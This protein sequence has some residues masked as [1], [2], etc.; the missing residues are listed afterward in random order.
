MPDHSEVSSKDRD[1]RP[2]ARS[3]QAAQGNF[4]E[5]QTQSARSDPDQDTDLRPIALLRDP[6]MSQGMGGQS[7]RARLIRQLQR[8]SGNSYTAGVVARM[9]AEPMVVQR[10]PAPPAPA[11]TKQATPAQSPS[12]APGAAPSPVPGPA[13]GG[14]GGVGPGGAGGSGGP[15]ASSGGGAGGTGP[16]AT[17]TPASGSASGSGSGGDAGAVGVDFAAFVGSAQLAKNQ[18]FE[19][20]TARKQRIGAAADAEKIAVG[21][22]L[23][24]HVRRLG[25]LYDAGI[26]RTQ[27]TTE[28]LRTQITAARDEQVAAVRAN[29]DTELDNLTA[30]VTAN[31]TAIRQLS[32]GQAK[33]ATDGGEAEA[34]RA[35]TGSQQRADQAQAFGA[36]KIAQFAGISGA[37]DITRLVQEKLPGLIQGFQQ[38]GNELA[39]MARGDAATMAGNFTREG[40]QLASGEF[41]KPLDKGRAKI[42]S[43]RDDAVADI[44]KLAQDALKEVD[45]QSEALLRDLRAGKDRDS[46]AIR[47]SLPLAV[48]DINGGCKAAQD[49]VDASTQQGGQDV[50]QFTGEVQKA[51]PDGPFVREAQAGLDQAVQQ[52]GA[53]IDGFANSAIAAFPD[54][55]SKAREQSASMVDKVG[56]SIDKVIEFFENGGKE[57]ASKLSQKAGEIANKAHAGMREITGDASDKLGQAIREAMEKWDTQRIDGLRSISSK[58]DLGLAREDMAL[59]EFKSQ[60]D[61]KAAELGAK[62]GGSGVLAAIGDALLAVVKF[63]GGAIVGFFEQ[64]WVALKAIWEL[65]KKPLFWIVVAIVAVVLIALIIIFGWEAIVAALGYVLKALVVLGIIAGIAFASYYVYL[66][67]TK[68]NLSAYERGKLFGRAIFEVVL[69]FAGTGVWARLGRFL[70]EIGQIARLIDRIGNVLR[71][72]QLFSRIR[73][74]ELLANLLEKAGDA[75]RLLQMLDKVGDAEKLLAL[76]NK[77]GDAELTFK[78][79]EKVSSADKLLTLL[80][81]VPKAEQVLTLLEKVGDADK[82]IALLDKMPDVE[83]LL[84]LLAKVPNPDTLLS[85]LQKVADGPKLLAL[86]EKVPN[87]DTLLKLLDKLANPDQLLSLLDKVK[88]PDK[89]LQ[90][91]DVVPDFGKLQRLLDKVRD[92]DKLIQLLQKAPDADKLLELLNLIEAVTGTADADKALQ[93]LNQVPDID[94]L[95]LSIDPANKA[96]LIT[97]KGLAEGRIGLDLKTSGKLPG[98]TRDPSGAAEFL[99]GKAA[100]DI[101]GFNSS[102]PPTQGGFDLV[103]DMQKITDSISQGE[104]VIVDTSKMSPADIAA[105]QAEVARRGLASQVVFHP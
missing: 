1:L 13:D 34:A 48:E 104:N 57:L 93:A 52:H 25:D 82:L 27:D 97:P 41:T 21:Q 56:G 58:V 44:N 40:E 76:L 64:A 11:D 20:A 102:R 23:D 103:R 24:E 65:I 2:T 100:W 12:G 94:L 14:G 50:D 61:A 36:Q 62:G 72:A 92:A 88:D 26:K 54:G 9:R 78:L 83:E 8:D 19:A 35:L 37:G 30:I 96:Q 39:T 55:T 85:L 98:L 28:R 63:I 84:K 81:R 77:V 59:A 49:K 17:Q 80:G 29:A 60:V 75:E 4:G 42:T 69:A 3:G 91:L 6:R 105:L 87:A 70:G 31:Q 73:D 89:L 53:E 7:M 86:L 90:L 79:I 95:L 10:S 5:A 32:G 74:L 99:D 15:G 101:K 66:M 45:K 71:A 43:I 22:M 47:Q 38:T 16:A 18:M 68:P 33:A 46:E 67:I 51:S